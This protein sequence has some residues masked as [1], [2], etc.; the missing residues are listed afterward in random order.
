MTV[1]VALNPLHRL[2]TGRKATIAGIS[3]SPEFSHRLSALGLR[4]G[5]MIEVVRRAPF[6][7]PLHLRIGTTDV[8]MRRQDAAGITVVFA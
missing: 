8:I 5:E 1:N 6:A 2:A 4:V 3:V 7:G